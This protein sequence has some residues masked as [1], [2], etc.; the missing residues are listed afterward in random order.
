MTYLEL[1]V[2]MCLGHGFLLLRRHSNQ[3]HLYQ[4]YQGPLNE[5]CGAASF[6]CWCLALL[7]ASKARCCFASLIALM[8]R[9]RLANS[10]ERFGSR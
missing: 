10:V 1:R 5:R 3:H 4:V 8:K 9:G 7:V 6:L 2:P